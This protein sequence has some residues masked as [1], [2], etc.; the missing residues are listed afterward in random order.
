MKVG[1]E[2]KN[3]K[4]ILLFLHL[5]KTAGT[6]MNSILDSQYTKKQRIR[7]YTEE[8][9]DFLNGLNSKVRQMPNLKCI[10]GHFRFGIH[11]IIEKPSTYITMLRHPIDRVIST[12][13]FIRSN[14]HHPF[15]REAN[16]MNLKDFVLS[17]DIEAD[18]LV[19]N[20]QTSFLSGGY[21]P[22]KKDHLEIAKE[23]LVK[24]FEVVGITER[25]NESIFLMK[26]ALGWKKIVYKSKN[27]TRN[28][29]RID[30]LSAE[31]LEI[32]KQKNQLDIELYNFAVQL[33][34]K[35]VESLDIKTKKEMK[36]FL[37]K[38]KNNK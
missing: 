31:I 11:E 35:Q 28:R 7:Y 3:K 33:F 22:P 1:R 18:F 34:E 19:N 10:M 21:Y 5:P 12:F 13:Y 29:P 20:M 4:T 6:T 14:P 17:T 16:N 36:R 32:I 27:I 9:S 30:E 38:K 8:Y 15:Y 2:L 37:A 25:F 24:Y 26:K 23:N